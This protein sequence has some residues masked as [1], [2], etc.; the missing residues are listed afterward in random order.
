MSNIQYITDD[1]GSQ[2]GVILDME[3]YRNLMAKPQADPDLLTYLNLNELQALAG[4]RLA[5]STRE[6]L[7]ILLA[8]NNANE[9]TDTEAVELDQLLAQIGQLNLLK[10]RVRY[11]LQ[12]LVV[13]S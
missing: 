8:R 13:Q 2:V 7:E 11:T 10:T 3:D 6:R 9:H 5:L 1:Q 12:Q 4:S